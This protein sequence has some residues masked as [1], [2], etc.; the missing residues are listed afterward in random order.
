MGILSRNRGDLRIYLGAAPGVG[1][2][3]SMLAEAHRR[4]ERGTDVIAAV[5]E[6]H[7]RRK[8]AQRLAGIEVMPPRIVEHD[9]ERHPEIDLPAI[10]ERR[11]KVVLVDD[12]AHTNAPG[13]KNANRWQDV[14]ELLDAG[15]TV[16]TTVSVQNLESLADI[17]TQ[18]TGVETKE[19]IPD[20]IVRT[21]DQIELVDITPQALQRRLAHGNIYP[22]ERVDAAMSNYFRVENLTALRQLALLWLA[23]QVDAALAKYRSD[24]K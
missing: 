1:K 12:L 20:E 14:E 17:A 9:G 8:T 21:A 4:M 19:R 15:I 5:V 23:D 13:S 3:Y 16:I 18:I 10:L 24:K 6:T 2:T 11:P 7:G 22:P